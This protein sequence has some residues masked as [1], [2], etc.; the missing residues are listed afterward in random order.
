MANTYTQIH[1]QVIFTVKN[2]DCII[3][4]PW[5]EELY[6]YI[7]GIIKNNNHKLLAINGMPDHVHIDRYETQPIFVGLNAGYKR[8]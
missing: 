2:R 5:K 6:K 8:R 7:A 3:L 1:I 4:K